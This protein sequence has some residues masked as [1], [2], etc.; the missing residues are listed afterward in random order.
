MSSDAPQS[1]AAPAPSD[2]PIAVAATELQQVIA[3]VGGSDESAKL[4]G[5]ELAKMSIQDVQDKAMDKPV[6]YTPHNGENR[7]YM[8]DVRHRR[9]SFF[10]WCFHA[11]VVCTHNL[12]KI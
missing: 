10:C 11:H 3:D 1:A 9:S 5:D 6:P 2:A 8:R 4:T 7:Q 12:N